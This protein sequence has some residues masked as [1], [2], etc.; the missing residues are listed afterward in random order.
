MAKTVKK[1]NWRCVW[2][3]ESLPPN[4]KSELTQ[5]GL[6][7]CCI[8]HDKD[9]D[10]SEEGRAL[11]KLKK[12]HYHLILCYDGPTTFNNVKNLCSEFNQPIPL[13]CDSIR[14]AYNYFT[15]KDYP[16]KHQY[17]ES[18][19]ERYNG[20]NIANFVEM[21]SSEV[22]ATKKAIQRYIRDN[23][24]REY[25]VLM[26]KLLDEEMDMEWDIASKHTIF[27]DKYISSRRYSQKQKMKVDVETG[28][29][30]EMQDG[31]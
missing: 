23:D 19:I 17:D 24:I 5:R 26:D 21:T 20:F 15:H 7:W 22:N 8:K 2:W 27:F 31:C 10:E 13:P 6:V 1:R 4:W 25:G 11:G 18:L 14:G 9:L 3:E 30:I 29:V 16:D 12:T 28:E